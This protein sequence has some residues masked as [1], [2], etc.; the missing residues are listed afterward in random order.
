MKE[1]G[2]DLKSAFG[3]RFLDFRECEKHKYTLYLK[4]SIFTCEDYNVILTRGLSYHVGFVSVQEIGYVDR[5][6]RVELARC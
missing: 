5:C 6:L 1:L 4:G 3:C 2:N